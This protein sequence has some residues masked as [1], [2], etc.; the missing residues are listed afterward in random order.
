MRFISLVFCFILLVISSC[1]SKPQVQKVPPVQLKNTIYGLLL[2]QEG[3]YKFVKFSNYVDRNM[4]EPWVNLGTNMPAWTYADS[5][6]SMGTFNR[7]KPCKDLKSDLFMDRSVDG[8]GAAA[9]IVLAPVFLGTTLGGIDYKQT[10]NTSEYNQALKEALVELNLSELHR[11]DDA[12]SENLADKD[13][14]LKQYNNAIRDKSTINF[15][16]TD[17]TGVYKN[18][19]NFSE[20]VRFPA[21]DSKCEYKSQAN[22]L[23]DL[24]RAFTVSGMEYL[25]C[26]RNEYAQASPKC[27]GSEV[28]DWITF[29]M[30][31]PSSFAITGERIQGSVNVTINSIAKMRVLPRNFELQDN[32]LQVRFNGSTIGFTNLTT[33]F[34]QID[35]VAFYYSNKVAI[36]TQNIQMA[37]L[38]S[39]L[40]QDEVRID[41]FPIDWSLL[42]FSNVTRSTAQTPITFGFAIKYRIVDTN[43]EKTLMKTSNI[44]LADL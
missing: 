24:T 22:Y 4:F 25:S 33:K 29:S 43:Q 36:Q 21:I 30:S 15:R 1:A 34:I 40:P 41:R 6:C 38:S 23:N 9:R 37:P 18:N 10:L 11:A 44:K 16:I 14:I 3:K 32:A 31:C 26:L 17:K 42:S 12:L 39:L 8:S 20:F 5:E 27:P 2:K 35:N 28:K 13:I 19:L 7:N